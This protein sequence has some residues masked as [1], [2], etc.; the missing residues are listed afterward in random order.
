M[1]YSGEGSLVVWVASGHAAAPL[2]VR[3]E[4][5]AQDG[6]LAHVGARGSEYFLSACAG[7]DASHEHGQPSRHGHAER[8]DLDAGSGLPARPCCTTPATLEAQHA[9]SRTPN[10]SW[11]SRLVGIDLPHTRHRRSRASDSTYP[12][13]WLPQGSGHLPNRLPRKGRGLPN[14]LPQNGKGLLHWIPQ[15]AANFSKQ[16]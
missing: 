6:L 8:Q 7:V 9:M 10:V 2:A 16:I 3:S 15:Q 12:L 13:A 5:L 11:G 4:V 14:W 1:P